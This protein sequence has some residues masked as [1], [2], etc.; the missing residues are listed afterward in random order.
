MRGTWLP[1]NNYLLAITFDIRKRDPEENWGMP[2]ASLP[3]CLPVYSFLS[4][5]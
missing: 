4:S 5:S 2:P 1:K 3:L